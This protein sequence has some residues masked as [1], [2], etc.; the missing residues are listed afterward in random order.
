MNG[1]KSG[2]FCKSGIGY[3]KK[4][5]E[6][7]AAI[8]SPPFSYPAIVPGLIVGH[9]PTMIDSPQITEQA[10]SPKKKAAGQSRHCD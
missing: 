9:Q 7:T 5:P 1:E 2:N 10:T 4:W 8:L 6:D 3:P